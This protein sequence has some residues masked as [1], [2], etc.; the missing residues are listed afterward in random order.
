MSRCS[1]CFSLNVS[2]SW[3]ARAKQQTSCPRRAPVSVQT[4]SIPAASHQPACR[5]RSSQTAVRSTPASTGQSEKPSIFLF[6]FLLSLL[7]CFV[8]PIILL[9]FLLPCFFS[10]NSFTMEMA[11]LLT[12][13]CPSECFNPL[14]LLMIWLE[15]SNHFYAFISEGLLI[16]FPL[17]V[18]PVGWPQTMWNS[19]G[20]G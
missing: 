13:G 1:I 6:C 15:A 2:L 9:D 17:T 5:A 14:S 4:A 10:S 11:K 12:Q 19:K 18:E 3:T 7:C 16:G 20:L 8:L